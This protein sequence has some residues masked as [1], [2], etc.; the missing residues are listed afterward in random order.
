MP[1]LFVAPCRLPA[2][3]VGHQAHGYS[4]DAST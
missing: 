3:H 1:S 4:Y 2:L